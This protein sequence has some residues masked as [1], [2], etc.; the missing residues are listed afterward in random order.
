MTSQ[1]SLQKL[2]QPS[3]VPATV[4]VMQD[5]LDHLLTTTQAAHI[6]GC[7]TATVTRMVQDGRLAPAL[8]LPGLRGDYLF[9]PAA[10]EA[11]RAATP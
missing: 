3:P 8:K 7:S 4:S 2:L 6:L 1:D 11:A 10:V 9:D 5:E